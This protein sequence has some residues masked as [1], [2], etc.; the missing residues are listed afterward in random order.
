M[1]DWYKNLSRSNAHLAGLAVK[2]TPILTI[3]FGSSIMIG[4]MIHNNNVAVLDS[5][6]QQCGINNDGNTI[7][8]PSV[9]G[10]GMEKWNKETIIAAAKSAKSSSIPDDTDIAKIQSMIKTESTGNEKA[11]QGDIGD[12][13]NITGDL[14]KGLL[15]F[16]SATFK[17][18]AVPGHNDIFN[19]MDSLMALFNDSNWKN[20]IHYGG[21]WGPTGHPVSS[22]GGSSALDI[23]S[24]SAGAGA[25]TQA[26]NQCK[27][28]TSNG[29]VVDWAK[30]WIGKIPYSQPQRTTFPNSLKEGTNADCSSFVWAVLKN[31]GY[32][33]SDTPYTTF[34][35]EQ[36]MDKID[37]KDAKAGDVFVM[38]SGPLAHTGILEGSWTGGSTPIINEGG[39]A[40]NVNESPIDQAMGSSWSQ[41][42]I[43]RP[44]KAK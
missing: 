38:V 22:S 25:G 23:A 42:D 35:M 10:A 24:S 16:T 7:I 37:P 27:N 6:T 2:H 26:S 13:N 39:C 36:Y 19:G 4:T 17:S 12:I 3:A 15:Q 41:V 14:A 32:E 21:G 34:N 20:D 18:Y 31:N 1:A 33:V 40:D 9:G 30:K 11:V 8:S 29:D 28:N 44:R 43:L 5:R